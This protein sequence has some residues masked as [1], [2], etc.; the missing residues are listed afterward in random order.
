MA[1]VV[2][3]LGLLALSQVATVRRSSC[4]ENGCI[5]ALFQMRS[6]GRWP[7]L[8]FADSRWSFQHSSAP[9]FDWIGLASAL[10]HGPCMRRQRLGMGTLQFH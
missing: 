4:N 9:F 1:A 8:G 6:M 7:F 3:S 2:T 5:L 10:D